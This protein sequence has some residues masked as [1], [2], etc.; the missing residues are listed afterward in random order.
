MVPIFISV[1]GLRVKGFSVPEHTTFLTLYISN[2]LFNELTVVRTIRLSITS[3][4]IPI[5]YYQNQSRLRNFMHIRVQYS[6]LSTV[7][8][9]NFLKP[10]SD[11]ELC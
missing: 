6:I 3:T 8:A 11:S 7:A 4:G 5:T 1:N 9:I 10:L 2:V